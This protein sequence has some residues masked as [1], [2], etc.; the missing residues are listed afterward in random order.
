[1][2]APIRIAIANRG[3]AAVRSLNTIAEINGAEGIEYRSIALYTDPDRNSMF[4]RR[5]HEAV[6]LGPARYFDPSDGRT[7]HTYLDRDKLL[8]ALRTARADAVWVGWGFLS[9]DADFAAGCEELGI[10]FIGPSSQTM[11]SLADKIQ[12]KR[13]AERAGVPVVPWSSGP[14]RNAEEA[15]SY[16]E[17]IGYPLVV[18]AATGGGGRG[19]REVNGPES[20]E[21]LFN[22][23]RREAEQTFGDPTVFLERRLNDARHVEVQVIGDRAGT[24]WALG[25]REC[26]VQRRR[27]KILEESSLAI[28][29]ASVESRLR[30]YALS[31]CNAV[32]YTNAGTVEFLYEPATDAIFFMEVNTRLQVE[33]TVTEMVTGVD[34]VRYQLHVA[35]GGRLEGAAPTASGHAIEV[36]LNAEDPERGF[37][38]APGRVMLYRAPSG[39]GV[40]V[41]SG[42]AQGDTIASEFDS[43]IAKIIVWGPDRPSALRRLR[44]ALE[45]VEV[46]IDGGATNKSFLLELVCRPEIAS[47]QFRTAWLNEMLKD[48]ADGPQQHAEIALVQAAVEAYE[49][50][51]RDECEHFL[52][53]AARGQPEFQDA[54]GQRIELRYQGSTYCFDVRKLR[55]ELY[56]LEMGEENSFDVRIER[57]GNY[58]RTLA[59]GEERYRVLAVSH[60]SDYVIEVRGIAH[61]VLRNDGGQVR[62]HY[63]ALVVAV[64]VGEG[65]DVISGTP[66]LILESMK[67]ESGLCAPF[68]G[69]VRQVLVAAGA[70]VDAGDV[71]A[72]IESQDNVEQAVAVPKINLKIA[73]VGNGPSDRDTFQAIESLLLGFDVDASEAN[74]ITSDLAT[75][76]DAAASADLTLLAAEQK[77]LTTFS[78]IHALTPQQS[79]STSPEGARPEDH[80]LSYL[81]SPE[82]SKDALPGD[83]LDDL[84]TAL[85]YYG[86]GGV[87][88]SPALDDAILRLYKSRRRMRRHEMIVVAILLRWR[89]QAHSLLDHATDTFRHLLDRLVRITDAWSPS[90]CDLARTV[91]FRLFDERMLSA[92]HRQSLALIEKDL[93]WLALSPDA[94]SCD[95]HIRRLAATPEPW[96][97]WLLPW[98]R[99]DEPRT[100]RIALELYVRIQYRH[101]AVEICD[102]QRT[103]SGTTIVRAAGMR[104]SKSAVVVAALCHAPDLEPAV[105]AVRKVIEPTSLSHDVLVEFVT[106]ETQARTAS[107]D[108]SPETLFDRYLPS[109]QRVVVANVQDK[110]DAAVAYRI[111]ERAPHGFLEQELYTYLHPAAAERLELWRLRNFSVTLLQTSSDLHLFAGIAHDNRRDERMFVVGEVRN[112]TPLRNDRGE[113]ESI[114][115]LELA[116]INCMDLFR[117]YH[118]PY[119]ARSRF[120][121]NRAVLYVEPPW[122]LPLE[123]L[124]AIAAR[125]APA[126][127]GLSLDHIALRLKI[128]KDGDAG[129]SDVVVHMSLPSGIG[130]Q[131]GQKAPSD[132]PIR[133]LSDYR[134]KSAEMKRLGF[135]YP[136]DII[137]LLTSPGAA[138]SDFPSGEFQEYDLDTELQLI[139]VSRAPGRNTANVVVG[140]ITNFTDK[141]PEGMS[142]VLILNDPSKSLGSLGEA[143][144]RRIL[145]ALDV[146]RQRSIPVEWFGV[147]SG[148]RV[149]MDSGTENLDWTARVL[150]SLIN[151]TQDGHEVNLILTGINVGAQSYWNAEAT[152]LMHTR[153]ILIMVGDSAMV[154]TGKQALDYSGAV[155]AENNAG[156]GGYDRIMG[157]NGQA[158]YWAPDVEAACKILFRHYQLTYVVPGERF[159]RR[160]RCIDPADRDIR[161]HPH[162]ALDAGCF[163]RVGEI[164]EAAA[165]PDRKKPFDIRSVMRALADSGDVPLERWAHMRDAKTAVV[166]D[167]HIGGIPVC[168]VGIESHELQRSSLAPADGPRRWNSGTLFPRSSKKV[169]RAINACSGNRPLLVLA[170]L[171]GFDGSPESMRELQL[172]YGAEIGRAVVNFKGPIIFCVLSR[173]HGGA[174]VVFSKAL[175][176]QLETVALEGAYA[177][178]LGGAPAAAVVF[179]REVE[180]RAGQDPRIADLGRTIAASADSELAG[181]TS[182]LTEL[183]EQARTEKRTEVAREFDAVHTINRA[184]AVGSIDRIVAA[185]SLRADI[186]GALERGMPRSDVSPEAACPTWPR[187]S[188]TKSRGVS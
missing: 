95:L 12:A 143:E 81:R 41:D 48:R 118:S 25:V 71:V 147:S 178:V 141:Q 173:Y 29:N 18:K 142:R 151:L 10:V 148:A 186:V 86:V 130:V 155:S 46:V 89:R 92:T 21:R 31:I 107:P 101:L 128:K 177:S 153:G 44:R 165:N 88:S 67:M 57:L 99:R 8:T 179:S 59:C 139:P 72:R 124:K 184:L 180:R 121:W 144:C 136:Y 90:V 169:A 111:W 110:S 4:V 162:A 159:P 26:S 19:I 149:S 94:P 73:L 5:A 133:T 102:L 93:E 168:M 69:R 175:N 106:L 114:P 164:F 74:R 23:A 9:E 131:V 188:M 98:I 37:A 61:R 14:V 76:H 70:Q 34:L 36:R 84:Q 80:L 181:L 161:E 55:Q 182:R 146:A 108:T 40:R 79:R 152:M 126:T 35:F 123:T 27:Q 160:A 2:R 120:A 11:R 68:S 15:R 49:E 82:R 138:Y 117:Q 170:N 150:R 174:F 125:A 78:D 119:P 163:N 28:R 109:A 77:V 116:L 75:L 50:N 127:R 132:E 157:G 85:G 66:L 16:A 38:P 176:D 32:G 172:E 30:Q 56:R 134:A 96:Q 137:R 104:G 45:Q 154:L 87:V 129:C 158:Q 62:S 166:W 63:P 105:L 91:R 122:N 83:F 17:R 47:G 24:I 22:D 1:M 3:E 97:D 183:I 135:V 112:L 43:M 13:I 54:E 58:E 187:T 60:G 42:I 51:V 39:H 6:H 156:I 171:S 65:Q 7:K 113:V 20:L 115:E 145:G 103:D 185:A 64:L 53:T 33:H 167:V 52:A 100:R 140:V